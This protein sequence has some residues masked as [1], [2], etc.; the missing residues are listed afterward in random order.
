MDHR[1]GYRIEHKNGYNSSNC[2]I[3]SSKEGET[4]N[5]TTINNYKRR[6]FS[7]VNSI[8]NVNNVNNVNN[9]CTETHFVTC[10]FCDAVVKVPITQR[11]VNHTNGQITHPGEVFR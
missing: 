8:I 3:T 2:S 6:R 9:V 5:S 10:Y 11:T 7:N 1:L 4:K